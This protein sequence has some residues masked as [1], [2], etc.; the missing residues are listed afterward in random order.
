MLVV[1][2]VPLTPNNISVT[3]ATTLST[4]ELST[5]I[6][7]LWKGYRVRKIFTDLEAVNSWDEFLSL[8]DAYYRK[9]EENPSLSYLPALYAALN[10]TYQRLW[11]EDDKVP[12]TCSW[13]VCYP[14]DQEDDDGN[15]GLD[16]NESGYFD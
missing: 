11:D 12:C 4:S 9:A 3:M 16:W 13:C 15:T 14:D 2:E 8:D 7:S 6:S 10:K 1:V 5:R